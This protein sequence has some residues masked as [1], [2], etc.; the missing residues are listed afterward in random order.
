VRV[1]RIFFFPGYPLLTFRSSPESNRFRRRCGLAPFRAKH[2]NCLPCGSFPFGVLPVVGSHLLPRPTIP[3]VT[4][5]SQRFARSQGFSPPATCRPY[6]MPVPPMG[7][8]PPGSCDV[9][10]AISSFEPLFPL[11]VYEPFCRRVNR[12][13]VHGLPRS[14]TFSSRSL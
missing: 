9:H 7:F 12:F 4:L 1:P 2:R 6:F 8:H 3:W 13:R 14:S 11:V 5:P 10:R